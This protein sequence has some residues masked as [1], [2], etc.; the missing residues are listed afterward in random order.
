M[1]DV[2]TENETDLAELRFEWDCL[3]QRVR[4]ELYDD[5]F[6]YYYHEMIENDGCPSLELEEMTVEEW[7][8]EW[9]KH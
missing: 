8:K 7:R 4:R 1:K 6:E 3:P 2:A 5:K 9:N